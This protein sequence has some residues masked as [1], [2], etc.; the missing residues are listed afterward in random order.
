VSLKGEVW[1]GSMLGDV[2]GGAG[3]T[4]N[5]ATG[6][7][8]DSLGGWL[9]LGLRRG[10]YT[11]SAG[12]TIDDPEDDDVPTNMITKNRAWYVTNAFRIAPPV[13]AGVDYT[14]WETQYKD[15][16]DGTDNRVNLYISYTF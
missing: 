6:Q 15:A 11:F 12:G 14:Y 3:Q 1:V 7:E 10:R 5:L 9:E 16:N 2:R 8:I 4:F 13:A